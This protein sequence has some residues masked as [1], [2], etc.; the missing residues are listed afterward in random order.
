[1]YK[2]KYTLYRTYV[3]CYA[4]VYFTEYKNEKNRNLKCERETIAT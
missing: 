3:K 2:N 1:M 4:D